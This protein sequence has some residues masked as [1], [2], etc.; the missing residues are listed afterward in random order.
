MQK[1]CNEYLEGRQWVLSYY[2]RGVPNW[3]WKF[4]HHYAPF[5]ST[6][7]KYI[8]KFEFVK[9][10]HTDP[11]IPFVQLLSV[12]PP[13]SSRLLPGP[14]GK[15][16]TDKDSDLQQF[17]PDEI[18]IDLEGKSRAWDGYCTPSTS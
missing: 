6:L 5:A 9:Y 2:T 13:L 12:L 15:L 16:L 17:C 4:P 18:D 7:A 11:N 8:N 3:K 1:L 10:G 14:L